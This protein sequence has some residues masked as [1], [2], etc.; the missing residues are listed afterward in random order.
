[1]VTMGQVAASGG[2][3]AAMYANHIT[4]TPYTITGSI[5]V[6]GSW[7]YDKGLNEK[8]GLRTETLQR[9]AHADLLSGVIIPNRDLRPEEEERYKK[10]ILDIYGV[11]L[12][13]VSAGRGMELA[14]VEAAAQGRVLSGKRALEAGLIDSIGGF[15]EA[16]RTVQTLAEIS[17]SQNI[18]YEE[19]P[20]P[21]F[22]EKV[23]ENFPQ[24]SVF[25]RN[26]KSRKNA[27]AHNAALI[28]ELLLPG[29]DLRYRLENNGRI[30][31]ILPLEFTFK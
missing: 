10:Y 26:A 1:V 2:Y 27:I 6:I 19:Y 16:L 13:K 9:G 7:F 14:K 12:E 8:L 23:M 21:S 24:T 11:F 5:G 15:P 29:V 25:S 17:D 18:K 31:P 4:A 28:E 20:K 30:L 22:W 3:W